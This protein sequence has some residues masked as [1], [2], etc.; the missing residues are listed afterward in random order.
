MLLIIAVC[1]WTLNLVVHNRILCWTNV[2]HCETNILLP[3]VS[4]LGDRKNGDIAAKRLVEGGY[5]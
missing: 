3:C 2:M 1:S 4:N 5:V